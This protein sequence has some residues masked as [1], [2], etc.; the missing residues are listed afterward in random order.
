MASLLFVGSAFSRGEPALE[1]AARRFVD[2][3]HAAEVVTG[4]TAAL[5]RLRERAPEVLITPNSRPDVDGIA[6]APVFRALV[7]QRKSGVLLFT[8]L[9]AEVGATARALAWSGYRD[10][11]AFV[12]RTAP[13]PGEDPTGSA[14]AHFTEQLCRSLDHVLLR[15][16]H[17][18]EGALPLPAA[19]DPPRVLL[20]DVGEREV[21]SLTWVSEILA[22]LGMHTEVLSD[23]RAALDRMRTWTPDLLVTPAQL[24]G[25]GGGALLAALGELDPRGR[26]GVVLLA[27]QSP[28]RTPPPP[29]PEALSNAHETV[30]KPRDGGVTAR[31]F[32]LEKYYR[33]QVINSAAH[34]LFRKG[35]RPPER[36][37]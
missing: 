5:A 20:L 37:T 12:L 10:V 17:A 34:V 32:E 16:G 9:Y 4:G 8:E 35:W 14:D 7:P 15:L 31:N 21:R 25:L 19:G 36:A 3:G 1:A 24:S 33:E 30:V 6:L 27:P 29:D 13:F 11:D 2:L 28:G 23:G 18:A 26:V 22:G